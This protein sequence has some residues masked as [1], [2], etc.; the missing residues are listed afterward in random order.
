MHSDDIN[1]NYFVIVWFWDAEKH[2]NLLILINISQTL[3]G[4]HHPVCEN[5]LI[6]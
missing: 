5:N 6:Y 4:L 3:Q 2:I 1:G